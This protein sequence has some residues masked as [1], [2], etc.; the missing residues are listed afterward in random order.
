MSGHRRASPCRALIKLMRSMKTP[1]TTAQTGRTRLSNGFTLVELLVVIAII[2][3]LAA[4][5]LPA[6]A[7]AKAKAHTARC[8]SNLR[9]FGIA[10]QLYTEDN[11][12]QFPFPGSSSTQPQNLFYFL[13]A[14][15]YHVSTNAAFYICPADRGPLTTQFAAS[16]NVQTNNI[17][18]GS[19]WL[20]PGFY[21]YN[22][23]TVPNNPGFV[24]LRPRYVSE[25]TYPSQKDMMECAAIPKVK[26]IVPNAGTKSTAHAPEEKPGSN[27]LFVDG[28]ASFHWWSRF[29]RDPLLGSNLPDGYA[30]LTWRDIK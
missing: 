9:Q 15:R 19:Y 27:C 10:M 1:Q 20:L 13:S 22:Q 25:V 26:W 5:L 28:H 8:L 3:I 18:P 6:L 14:L 24:V 11:S 4:L 17:L 16:M 7:K 12:D 30:S 29:Q 21:Y 2:A 23:N